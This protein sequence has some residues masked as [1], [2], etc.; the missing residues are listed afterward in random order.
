MILMS[1]SGLS[2][3][4]YVFPFEFC[5]DPNMFDLFFIFAFWLQKQV[6]TNFISFFVLHLFCL[7]FLCD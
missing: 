1:L 6:V 3:L 2:F 5:S 4:E 7:E